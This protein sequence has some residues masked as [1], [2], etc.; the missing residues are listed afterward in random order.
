MT[1]GNDPDRIAR[2]NP[3]QREILRLFQQFEA[4][5]IAQKLGISPHTVNEHLRDARRTLGVGRSIL[6]ARAL[7]EYERDNRIGAEPIG[8]GSED[9]ERQEGEAID[10]GLPEPI[11]RKPR[12]AFGTLQRVGLIVAVAV[13]AVVLLG[14]R[15]TRSPSFCRPSIST[16]PIHLTGN[17]RPALRGFGGGGVHMRKKRIA[18]FTAIQPLFQAAEASADRAAAEAAGLIAAMIET[19]ST[20]ELPIAAGVEMLDKL[21]AALSANVAARKLF[22]EAHALTPAL[23]HDLGLERMFGDGSPCPPTAAELGSN[24]VVP[25]AGAA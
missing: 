1:S 10:A 25:I 19:R 23:I 14:P 17:S 4:K 24:N 16:Y 15:L 7:S 12:Y 22:I 6:A 11:V 5:E 21:V 3:R 18:A 20:A 13:G 9:G 8:V 2:L